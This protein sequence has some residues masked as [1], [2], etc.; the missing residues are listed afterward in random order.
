MKIK[1]ENA[2][3]VMIDV[4]EKFRPVIHEIDAVIHNCGV[5]TKAAGLLGVRLLVTEQYPEGLGR[6]MQEIELSPE[7]K[8]YGKTSFSIFDDSIRKDICRMDA[9]WIVLFGIETHVCVMQSAIEAIQ[10]GLN[11]MVVCDAVSSRKSY[12]KE[13]ALQRMRQIG[14]HVVTTEMLLFELM[15]GA[16]HPAFRKISRLIK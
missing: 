8:V 6:T 16:D 1:V 15:E 12:S 7:T 3:F 14:C 4:Q 5:L 11:V 10:C 2:L 9:S 13:V